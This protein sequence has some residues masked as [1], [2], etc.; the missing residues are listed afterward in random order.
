MNVCL[1][2]K[3]EDPDPSWIVPNVDGELRALSN[4]FFQTS[5]HGF[6]RYFE[7]GAKQ[8]LGL[9]SLLFCFCPLGS[10]AAVDVDACIR[11]EGRFSVLAECNSIFL[12]VR[13]QWQNTTTNNDS[14]FQTNHVPWHLALS[15]YDV[16]LLPVPGKSATPACTL[17]G[18][19]Q[20]LSKQ[21]V[22]VHTNLDVT[23]P[24]PCF[25]QSRLITS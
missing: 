7:D 9:T 23:A 5:P 2:D 16:F 18:S 10:D 12:E 11:A 13:A 4:H 15:C 1:T 21:V 24:T 8:P 17:R 22:A 20:L 14:N 19:M 25:H 6:F 3:L